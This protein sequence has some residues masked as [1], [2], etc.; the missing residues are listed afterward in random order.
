MNK[1]TSA[2]TSETADLERRLDEFA[3]RWQKI[4][5]KHGAAQTVLLA[6]AL[7]ALAAVLDYI[8]PFSI[9][10]RYIMTAFCY[11]GI[12]TFAAFYWLI[13]SFMPVTPLRIAWLLEKRLPELNEKLISAV[14][15][16][17]VDAP[18]VS[19]DLIL[20][21]IKETG[22]DLSGIDP[23]DAL[24]LRR[25]YFIL[26]GAAAAAFLISAII[27]GSPTPR[28]AK[29]I[30][31]PSVRDAEVGAFRLIA[32]E[33]SSNVFSEDQP[34]KFAVH[35]TDMTVDEVLLEIEGARRRNIP[36]RNSGNGLFEL[37]VDDQNT[38]FS[39]R[40][41]A[42]RVATALRDMT[43]VRK[44]RIS[45]LTALYEFP[46]YT[47][48][49]PVRSSVRQGAIQALPQTVVTLRAS[50]SKPLSDVNFSYAGENLPASLSPDKTH[51]SV[52]FTV[53]D[54]AP[55]RLRMRDAE[56][57][58][59]E[60]VFEGKVETQKDSPPSITLHYP[61]ED[62]MIE[63][64]DLIALSWSA[65]DDFGIEELELSIQL[66]G[67]KLAVIAMPPDSD[68]KDF[69]TGPFDLT[70][71]DRLTLRVICR[72]GAGQQASTPARR[73][74]IV[75]GHDTTRSIAFIRQGRRLSETF[76]RALQ[77]Y[78]G[79]QQ[80]REA[81]HDAATY[82]TAAAVE[83][84]THNRAMLLERSKQ[85]DGSVAQTLSQAR[86]WMPLSFFPGADRYIGL[87][88]RY[89]EQ[90]RLHALPLL[91]E[92][93][94]QPRPWQRMNDVLERSAALSAALTEKAGEYQPWLVMNA[95]NRIALHTAFRSDEQSLEW[96]QRIS[97]RAYPF[98][99][100][101]DTQA[102]T[103]LRQ[104][105]LS[106]QQ[107]L[108]T[109]DGFSV[110]VYRERTSFPPSEPDEDLQPDTVRRDR[111]INFE[112]NR[113][114]GIESGAGA[115]HWQGY[116]LIEEPGRYRFF[117]TA[118][119]AS[120][121]YINGSRIIDNQSRHSMRTRDGRIDLERGL[122]K[123]D[124][125]YYNSGD[126]GHMVFEWDPPDGSRE[127]FPADRVYSSL[128][129]G[130]LKLA[131]ITG[132]TTRELAARAHDHNELDQIARQM[133]SALED[134]AAA[135][136]D[137][138]RRIDAGLINDPWPALERAADVFEETAAQQPLSEQAKAMRQMAEAY[139]D[140]AEK[141]D[142]ESLKAVARE[143]PAVDRLAVMDQSTAHMLPLLR[144]I[145]KKTKA[146]GD[147]VAESGD[148]ADFAARRAA[149]DIIEEARRELA[150]AQEQQI[151][152]RKLEDERDVRRV[153]DELRRADS[154][155]SAAA[156]KVMEEKSGEPTEQLEQ[157]RRA[158]SNAAAAMQEKRQE[159]LAEA[160]KSTAEL[161][162]LRPPPL[163][164]LD[165]V[166]QKRR[167][168]AETLRQP[169]SMNE[170]KLSAAIADISQD[171]PELEKVS[172]RWRREALDALSGEEPDAREAAA[173]MTLAQRVEDTR[174]ESRTLAAEINQARA[175]LQIPESASEAH[176]EAAQK[177][178]AEH[179]ETAAAIADRIAEDLQDTNRLAR[180]RDAYE[181]GALAAHEAREHEERMRS[182]IQDALP[183][184]VQ[185]DLER[186]EVTADTRKR[187]EQL[188]EALSNR[189]ISA[190]ETASISHELSDMEKRLAEGRR[191]DRPDAIDKQAADKAELA[192]RRS[193]DPAAVMDATETMRRELEKIEHAHRIPLQQ[194]EA[195]RKE[196]E[197][198]AFAILMQ[199][200]PQEREQRRW[201]DARE[202]FP[203]ES[204]RR[205]ADRLRD[206]ARRLPDEERSTADRM[207]QLADQL[208]RV[209]QE[210]GDPQR[211]QSDLERAAQDA[212]RR[213]AAIER[214]VNE[215]DIPEKQTEETL[216]K[217]AERAREHA[218]A[219]RIDEAKASLDAIDRTMKAA[220]ERPETET[221]AAK[222]DSP[223]PRELPELARMLTDALEHPQ[224]HMQPLERAREL[225]DENRFAEAAAQAA[226]TPYGQEAKKQ[227]EQAE[228]ALREAA[229]NARQ[230]MLTEQ[231]RDRRNA[232]RRAADAVAERKPDQAAEHIRNL[233]AEKQEPVASKLAEAEKHKAAALPALEA[234]LEQ[235]AAQKPAADELHKASELLRDKMQAQ[236]EEHKA[237]DAM[238]RERA[239]QLEQASKALAENDLPAAIEKTA[240]AAKLPLT[241]PPQKSLEDAAGA[242]SEAQLAK[243]KA[244]AAAAQ[245][246][247]DSSDAEAARKLMDA[248]K[249]IADGELE[250][251]AE[252]ARQMEGEAS[253]TIPAIEEALARQAA[254]AEK[255]AEAARD[256]ETAVSEAEAARLQAW[257]ES[258]GIAAAR[259]ALA[260]GDF[261]RAAD[262]LEDTQP[263]RDQDS[264]TERPQSEFEAAAK[265][266][267]EQAA[268]KARDAA[269]DAAKA[270]DDAKEMIAEKGATEVPREVSEALQEGRIADAAAHAVAA[271]QTRE[272]PLTE[273][274]DQA[275]KKADE[276]E[277]ALQ[278]AA[279][280]QEALG[281]AAR[282][283]QHDM[284][285]SLRHAQQA[286]TAADR[287]DLE[288]AQQELNTAREMA[289]QD[290]RPTPVAAAARDA[291]EKIARQAAAEAHAEQALEQAAEQAQSR[292]ERRAAEAARQAAQQND[293]ESA[294][295]HAQQAG[296]AGELAADAIKRA[297]EARDEAE[298]AVQAA[299][300]MSENFAA[301]AEAAQAAAEKAAQQAQ[302]AA[303]AAAQGQWDA[304][305]E[306]MQQAAQQAPGQSAAEAA[307]QASQ[308]T[309]QAGRDAEIAQRALDGAAE[310]TTGETADAIQQ[311]A[312]QADAGDYA[313]AAEQAR[314]AGEQGQQAAQALDKAAQ[315]AEQ[316]QAAMQQAGQAAQQAAQQA[317]QQAA[318]AQQAAQQMQ[319]AQQALQQGQPQQA[320]Q[321]MADAHRIAR[322]PPPPQPASQSAAEKAQ[323]EMRKM[324][325]AVDQWADQQTD[326]Q[327]A[328]IDLPPEV[329]LAAHRADPAALHEALASADLPENL[330]P[331]ATEIE[332]ISNRLPELADYLQQSA[333]WAADEAQR[334]QESAAALEQ[335]LRSASRI[336]DDLAADRLE[337]AA[338]RL[339]EINTALA[340]IPPALSD[341]LQDM[342]LA[343]HDMAQIPGAAPMPETAAPPAATEPGAMQPQPGQAM[344][345]QARSELMQAA[346]NAATPATTQQAA[347]QT[348]QASESMAQAAQQMAQAAAQQAGLA[349]MP[350]MQEGGTGDGGGSHAPASREYIPLGSR[351]MEDP[352]SGAE[353][354]LDSLDMGDDAR[355]YTPYYQRAMQ[356]YLRRVATERARAE[357]GDN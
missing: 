142:T 264:A 320:Q 50:F 72:D 256:L 77:Q 342:P 296:T 167:E 146:A 64:G 304:A 332:A 186:M 96:N 241:T 70:L 210:H 315:A 42:G 87:M 232:L 190:D 73:A 294:A 130:A 125:V 240:K 295:E 301:A 280:A 90:E 260:D 344:M 176:R 254:A 228:Q 297:A 140:S 127:I 314:Q 183:D 291:M 58:Y 83:N 307:R 172:T 343:P 179:I 35:T 225:A 107:P 352:W 124:L 65:T 57:P 180:E 214:A 285:E 244:R 251:A 98:V 348:R 162:R 133:E 177:R 292:A 168:L 21:L 163:D 139:R 79:M 78:Q 216:K 248:A 25:Y 233:P 255:I 32:Q 201:E 3:A 293:L 181:K 5:L 202:R 26:A 33:P 112:N 105:D 164:E 94:E 247:A 161:A 173:G 331:R 10:Q 121:L 250:K 263:S 198:E 191:T 153:R 327:L 120:R 277:Q 53:R 262:I 169:D 222:D 215:S 322:H 36:M 151:G 84:F 266:V 116:M 284:D 272:T 27:P 46:E 346:Q 196:P 341:L 246:A 85:L 123:I 170:Q 325:A 100:F 299:R 269:A 223:E 206:L 268:A 349:Q 189:R 91:P 99:R 311:A 333:A 178:A 28:L 259:E 217:L 117:C 356:D 303:E 128:G 235:A 69:D 88:R 22:N 310:H 204:P 345:D 8:L 199:T 95:M 321:S 257:E 86:N 76:E 2:T 300:Q 261:A 113:A 11:L 155:L 81:L 219:G 158:V 51:A 221:V 119:E 148:D 30:L 276:A 24:P 52:T 29:R 66:N 174:A 298:A 75:H 334:E 141:N 208:A 55:F 326:P 118:D 238:A 265:R 290:T 194:A 308:Q 289:A 339:P 104:L 136:A 15:L 16:E 110:R 230:E 17:Q 243:Q 157:A 40:F 211:M 154:A 182:A 192:P 6:I 220:A 330:L 152:N 1:N 145:E 4:R 92:E 323:Q 126:N 338:S 134:P 56:A 286:K 203:N 31:I 270:V 122:I 147:T 144:E 12:A 184:A 324:A 319:A 205:Q 62:L 19:R 340:K 267:A 253:R 23:S 283:R 111:A 48:R 335:A 165:A 312:Q 353:G 282:A 229:R 336:H 351:D 313:A 160:R 224:R 242:L 156:E 249:A 109:P 305:Q 187:A 150:R 354:Q 13:P 252:T 39:Y 337:R 82:R 102:A 9:T 309:E 355:R 273:A 317:Q 47:R 131:W 209:E 188:S 63:P 329:L 149:A 197:S 237:R 38:S 68:R 279:A 71:G 239:A 278:Q 108:P 103:T 212:A 245:D 44:P 43:L 306:A 175:A 129:N 350:S 54:E 347:Q 106:G 132:N 328:N 74:L 288:T 213:S 226:R 274:L 45:E 101:I 93:W 115:L 166:A 185:K 195:A 49:E 271:D 318:I 316:A 137:L 193:P 227:L 41:R 159:A 34:I 281:D 89:M 302:Q 114:L 207:N 135:V 59:A 67:R 37:T 60:S 231:D 236:I 171:D 234:A 61:Q 275:R 143:M 7:I 80:L 287:G 14:E 258:S 138:A 18:Q 200:E 218:Q 20:E 357:N 97:E